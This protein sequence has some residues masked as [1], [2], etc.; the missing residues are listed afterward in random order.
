MTTSAPYP[1]GTY[2]TDADRY[3]D[4]FVAALDVAP[5]DRIGRPRARRI[6]RWIAFGIVLTGLA[7]AATLHHDD[8]S[9]W[10]RWWSEASV[11]IAPLLERV[12]AAM[13]ATKPASELPPGTAL[14]QQD[15]ARL[16]MARSQAE[17]APAA[18]AVM[19]VPAE[20]VETAIAAP[21]PVAAVEASETSAQRSTTDDPNKARAAKAG[22]NPEISRVVLA[23]LSD[24]DYRNAAL[25]IRTALAETADDAVHYWPLK[26]KSG[27]AQFQ[28]HFVP[29]AEE[30]CRR[31]VVTVAKDGWATTALPMDN[32]TV[33]RAAAKSG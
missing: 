10:P 25:A 13:P 1:Y 27:V 22:L 8:P 21:P 33:K 5:A 14:S 9:R 32:C 17:P 2:S 6:G 19:A 29:G 15:G 4:H 26:V 18:D 16:D 24:V 3:A 12:A 20:P 23:R 31:Y 7:G 28:V 11:I 30:G